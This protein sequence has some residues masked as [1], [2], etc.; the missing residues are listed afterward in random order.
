MSEISSQSRT[1][2]KEAVMEAPIAW[3]PE[4]GLSAFGILSN[5][6]MIADSDLIIRY[7]NDA[8]MNMFRLIEG[9]ICRDLPHF[10][11]DSVINKNID[12]FHKNATFQRSLISD[13]K[14]PHDGRFKIGGKTLGFR[15]TPVYNHARELTSYVVEW[16]DLSSVLEG[17]E[18]VKN[19]INSVQE[20]ALKHHEGY[21][22]TRVPLENLNGE[23]KEVAKSVNAMVGGHIGTKRKIIECLQA[24]ANG[25]FDFEMEKLSGDREFINNAIENARA[26][27]KQTGDEIEEIASSIA[28]GDFDREIDPSKF[29][30][31]YQKIVS[32]LK[33]GIITLNE[34]M[35]SIKIQVEQISSAISQVNGSASALS[36]SSQSQA[37]AV[38]EISATIEQTDQMVR[39]TADETRAM[40][41]TVQK[42]V[43]YTK[44]GLNKIEELIVAMQS[45]NSSSQAIANIMKSIDEIAFQTNLLALNAAVEAARAGQHGRGFAVVAQEVRN[46]AGRSAKAA[47]ETSDLIAIARKD[48]DRGVE[49]TKSS[50][51]A[52]LLIKDEIVSIEGV[53][54]N[55][56]M[57]TEEQSRGIQQIN[58]AVNSLSKTGME[59]STHAEELASAST[60]MDASTMNV[61][62]TIDTFKLN[63]LNRKPVLQSGELD[64]LPEN[65]KSQILAFLSGN[66]ASLDVK[67]SSMKAEASNTNTVDFDKRGYS[68]F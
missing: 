51:E 39:S 18:Q 23:Y 22:N 5:P 4:D 49:A 57:A 20:M 1:K 41:T 9:D 15:L 10:R 67:K 14:K 13:L 54:G 53:V 21:I 12:F 28:N 24:F 44:T 61:R 59:I 58:L 16:Q 33:S 38:N 64:L 46:L 26:A 66:L 52:F 27:F 62:H 35:L 60:E 43:D 17:Q 34:S 29:Q 7:V 40:R 32:A 31:G 48:V 36:E 56:S 50:E 42:T 55:I 65:I 47:R 19:L 45:I 25:D 68:G 3:A 30:G 11:A 63:N 6:I 2:V 37:T 8:A